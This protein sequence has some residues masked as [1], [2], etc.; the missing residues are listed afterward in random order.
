MTFNRYPS[1]HLCDNTSIYLGAALVHICNFNLL[2]QSHVDYD[3][4]RGLHSLSV[5]GLILAFYLTIDGIPRHIIIQMIGITIIFIV[6]Q[7]NLL[8][9]RN[10][11]YYLSDIYIFF[12][13]NSSNFPSC[14]RNFARRLKNTSH[15][16]SYFVVRE[17]LFRNINESNDQCYCRG[18]Y[19]NFNLVLMDDSR[20]YTYH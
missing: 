12:V 6:K 4:C 2:V 13:L 15:F 8:I 5:C 19:Y 20:M 18:R 1:Y 16:L 17:F 10:F 11:V 9:L 3:R 7:N 14:N